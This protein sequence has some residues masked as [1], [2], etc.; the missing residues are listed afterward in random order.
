MVVLSRLRLSLAFVVLLFD[1]QI[2]SDR[3]LIG[4]STFCLRPK[5][6]APYNYQ[7]NFIFKNLH[8]FIFLSVSGSTYLW[9]NVGIY[10][11]NYPCNSESTMEYWHI[12]WRGN[13]LF[14]GPGLVGTL[15]IV[16]LSLY[17]YVLTFIKGTNT[18]SRERCWTLCFPLHICVKWVCTG[19]YF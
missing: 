17:E 16:Y 14:F 12:T 10:S 18:E 6:L 13:R 1:V 9:R 11:V 4:K 15:G 3:I 2:D 5:S 19:F 7:S 8:G